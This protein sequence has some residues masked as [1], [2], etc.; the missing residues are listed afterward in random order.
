MPQNWTESVE[1]L[2]RSIAAQRTSRAY[3]LRGRVYACTRQWKLAIKDYDAA[4]ELDPGSRAARQARA[5]ALIPHV[6]LPMLSQDDAERIS[7]GV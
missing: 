5:E 1:D 3:L 6:P 7:S 2:N 4:L